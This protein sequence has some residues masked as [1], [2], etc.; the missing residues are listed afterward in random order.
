M[1]VGRPRPDLISRCLPRVGAS[2]QVP[3]GLSTHHI[4]TTTNKLRLDDGFKV[5]LP[6]ISDMYPADFV[7]SFPSGHSSCMSPQRIAHLGSSKV[8]DY[9]ADWQCHL[10]V[11]ASWLYI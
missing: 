11:L 10:L 9:I 6:H 2:D 7:Q 3:F 8:R 5:C 1:S 4:C